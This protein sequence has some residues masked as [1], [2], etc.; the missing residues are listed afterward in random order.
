MTPCLIN[1]NCPIYCT[2]IRIL[3]VLFEHILYMSCTQPE[4]KQVLRDVIQGNI[5]HNSLASVHGACL[6]LVT[7]AGQKGTHLDYIDQI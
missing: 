1:V 2:P 7:M 5:F 6:I 4:E 3:H